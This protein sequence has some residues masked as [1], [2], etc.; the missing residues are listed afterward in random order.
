MRPPGCG[1]ETSAPWWWPRGDGDRH[2]TE[3][4]L[5]R[6][7][8]DGPAS[9]AASVTGYPSVSPVPPEPETDVAEAAASMVEHGWSTA[10]ATS[11]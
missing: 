1:T 8:A 7:M 6:A 10:S 5:L 4:D 3:R 2:L 9:R 11:P